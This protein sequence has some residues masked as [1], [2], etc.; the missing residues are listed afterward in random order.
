MSKLAKIFYSLMLV[1]VIVGVS[2][3]FVVRNGYFNTDN[4]NYYA[5]SGFAVSK[6][7]HEKNKKLLIEIQKKNSGAYLCLGK[8]GPCIKVKGTN[9]YL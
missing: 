1:M 3:I 4:K 7:Q 9:I 2:G 6:D 8:Y 5:L